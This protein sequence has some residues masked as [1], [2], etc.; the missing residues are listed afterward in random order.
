MM[1][2]LTVRVAGKLEGRMGPAITALKKILIRI[3]LATDRPLPFFLRNQYILKIY[4]DA[5]ATYLPKPYQGRGIYIKS[6]ERSPDHASN[7]RGLM[8]GGLELYEVASCGH[9]DIIK[10]D[11]APLWVETLRKCLLKAQETCGDRVNLKETYTGENS[12]D[13]RIRTAEASR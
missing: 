12:E 3:Y 11:N 1:K 8:Q 13:P 9:M 2:Y 7:W 6:A 10:D 4:Y 5:I